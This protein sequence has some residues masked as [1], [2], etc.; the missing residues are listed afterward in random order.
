MKNYFKDPFIMEM[1]KTQEHKLFLPLINRGT[2]CRVFSINSL[3]YKIIENIPKEQNIN[4]LV[5]GSGFD[6][7]YF[8]LMSQKHNNITFLEFDY[9]TIINKKKKI[10][11]K[12]KLLKDIISDNYHLLS[13]DITNNSQFKKSIESTISKEKLEDLTIVICECLLVYIDRENT[14]DMLL[15]LK[16]LFPNLI[17]LEYDLIGAKDA[18]GREM[19]D[20]LKMRNIELKGY[21]EVPDIKSQIERLKESKLEQVEIVDLLFVYNKMLPKNE[22]RRIDLLEM[23]DEFEEFN[24][25]QQ[26]ACFGYG[27]A[28]KDNK[29]DKIKELV[30]LEN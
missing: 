10:I 5:L 17:V 1:E 7:L 15:T 18:F 23:M 27:L 16:N 25:L 12:S 14:I 24:L 2:F 9:Q 22:R 11:E 29:F 3:I 26:H 8:N 21:E 30:K 20:N 4:F 13:C 19:I 28:F 6:T